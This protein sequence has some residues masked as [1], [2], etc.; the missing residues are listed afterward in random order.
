MLAPS[1]GFSASALQS[2]AL[3]NNRFVLHFSGEMARQ[4]TT[5]D[6]AVRRIL[7]REP[8]EAEQPR[9]AAY[10]QKHGLAALCR[11]LLNSNEFLFV[12]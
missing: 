7:L 4:L 6:E 3:Y 12:E 10:A 2:L 1:R 5:P 8:T 9:Y 11:V